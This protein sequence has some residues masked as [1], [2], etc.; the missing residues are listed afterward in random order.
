MSDATEMCFAIVERARPRRASWSIQR[1]PVELGDLGRVRGPNSGSTWYFSDRPIASDRRLG[2]R[3]ALAAAP[4]DA[5]LLDAVE[6]LIG[7]VLE[8]RA[9]RGEL[10]EVLAAG[11]GGGEPGQ[12]LGSVLDDRLLPFG[13]AA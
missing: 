4:A 13:L 7:E 11:L 2:V 5:A 3:L 8:E 1:L 6:P 12:D 10:A 9:A